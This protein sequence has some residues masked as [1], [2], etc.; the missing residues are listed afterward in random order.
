MQKEFSCRELCDAYIAHIERVD[1]QVHAFLYFDPEYV[2]QQAAAADKKIAHD[3]P[4][5]MMTGQ[6]IAIKDLLVTADM[7]TTAASKIL[8]GYRSAYDATAVARL[9]SA[10]AILTGK[11]N[12]DE[13]GMGSS[14]ENSAYGPTKN[15]WDTTKVPGGSSSGSAAAVAA[16]LSIG[17]LGTDTG[18]SVRQ[19]AGFCGIVGIKPTYGR[20]SRNGLIAFASSLDTIGVLGRTVCDTAI[21]LNAIAGVDP[22]D[23]TS[24]DKEEITIERVE[25]FSV[26]GMR[27]GIPK[28]Y[29]VEGID[30]HVEKSVRN[31]IAALES[32]GATVVDVSL[33]HTKDGMAV[34]YL[35]QPSEASANIA[36]YDGIRYG[37]RVAASSL[38]DIYGKSRDAGLGDEVKRRIMLGT[39]ALS[40]GYYDEY[41]RK[42]QKVR[43]VIREDFDRVF[44]DVD[45]L[46]TPTSPTLPFPLGERTSDPI[47]MYLADAFTVAAN[48][49]GIPGLSVPSGFHEGLPIGVQLMGPMWSEEL[50]FGVGK[51]LE[52]TLSLPLR[53]PNLA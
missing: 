4:I 21:L 18:S 8:E 51:L 53:L 33:P 48:I 15:P 11:T 41:Y 6:P 35:I 46:I 42:A 32:Q 1:P 13:F 9:R 2:R 29:F 44:R 49:A 28:E 39:F 47:A 17:A 27:L 19:P 37:K 3:A 30:P 26:Q 34:Y 25:A 38:I 36:R 16:G 7:P 5:G 14:G 22:R 40:A 23:A 12:C 31:A 50:L 24:I 20:V 43:T 10:G 45:V 52:R